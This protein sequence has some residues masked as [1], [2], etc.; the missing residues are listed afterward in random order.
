MGRKTLKA[1]GAYARGYVQPP[2]QLS[3][4]HRILAAALA[5]AGVLAASPAAPA[6]IFQ[7]TTG[8]TTWNTGTSWD[9]GSVPNATGANATFNGAATANNPAQTANRTASLDGTKTVGSILFNTDLSTF[10]NSISTGTGGTLTF[11]AT[12]AGP[13]TLITQGAGTGNNTI[14]V[15]MSFTDTLSA[16][17]NNTAASSAAGSLNL[18][19]TIGGVGGFSKF[20]DGTATFGTGAKTYTGPTLLSGGRMR[21]SQAA[22]PANS[23]SFTIAAGGQLDTITA[24]TYSLG[25]GTLNLNGTGASGGP[26][27]IFPGAI[28][29]DTGLSITISNPTVLQSDTLLHCQGAAAGLLTFTNTISGP[30]KL[31]LTAPNSNA[32][33]GTYTLSGANTYSGGT[34]ITGGTLLVSGATATLG[35]G[36]VTINNAASP[37]STT[38]RLQIAGGVLDAISDNATL[39]IAGGGA[40]GTADQNYVDLGAGV[41]ERVGRLILGGVEQLLPGTYG[42][43]ASS[44]DFKSDE[45]FAGTGVVTIP[46]PGSAALLFAATAGL[47]IRR[48]RRS[49]HISS[50]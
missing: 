49:P 3:R 28:R 47:L 22:A 6:D 33:I 27:A 26:N 45:Y 10:T 48:R 19:G 17:I 7:P 12:A 41:N 4:R 21:I 5:A 23:S 40:P 35:T 50:L 25:S 24:G 36:S 29:P 32:D 2:Q 43:T 31:S 15:A 11:D 34:Q 38:N 1:S 30:G 46:E 39:N 16:T 42:S 9:T 18:T 20:G 14:S 37:T 13:A 8:T 44:A